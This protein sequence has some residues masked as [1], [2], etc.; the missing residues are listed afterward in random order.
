MSELPWFQFFPSDWLGGTRTLTVV[1]T[2]VYITLIATMYDRGHPL[3]DTPDRLARL[4]G[5]TLRQFVGALKTLETSGKI[6]RSEDGLW[7]ERVDLECKKRLQKSEKAKQAAFAMWRGKTNKNNDPS[8]Q[9]HSERYANQKP[10]P[11]T[12]RKVKDNLSARKRRAKR[13]GAALPEGWTP[14]IE[15]WGVVQ[16]LGFSD[17]DQNFMLAE[18]RDW[19]AAH[20]KTMRNWDSCYRNWA[21]RELKHGKLRRSHPRNSLADGFA[22]LDQ[23]VDE[24]IRRSEE[25]GEENIVRL[26]GLRK[27]PA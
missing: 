12:S 22:K 24:A 10:E 21:R 23:V 20:G 5:A 2:G 27:G 14:T 11:E 17:D 26:P 9:T 18:M 4:C 8:M 3:T 13:A 15:S 16:D 19:A 1:E 7:N 25:G 6:L